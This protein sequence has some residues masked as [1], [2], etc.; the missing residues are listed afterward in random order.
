MSREKSYTSLAASAVLA[1]LTLL[2]FFVLQHYGPESAVRRF[3]QAVLNDSARELA[4]VT[5]Q[6]PG[7]PDVQF[8]SQMVRDSVRTGANIRLGRV[9]RERNRAVAEVGYVYPR[10][11]RVIYWVVERKPAGW[12]VNGKATTDLFRRMMGI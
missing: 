4:L 5:V 12:M 3:H 9:E 2:V 10:G 11:V 7:D 1:I 6:T 8:L